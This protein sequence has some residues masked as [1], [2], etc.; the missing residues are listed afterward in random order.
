M[1]IMYLLMLMCAAFT[2]KLTASDPVENQ[3]EAQQ[4]EEIAPNK[5]TDLETHPYSGKHR[6]KGAQ[7][8]GPDTRYMT[9]QGSRKSK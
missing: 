4:G 8:E 5:K 9:G 7:D 2:T 1:K 6:F 3:V